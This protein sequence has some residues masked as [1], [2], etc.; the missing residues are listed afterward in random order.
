MYTRINCTRVCEVECISKAIAIDI[1]ILRTYYDFISFIVLKQG[2]DQWN[3]VT[4]CIF[5]GVTL[6]AVVSLIIV[7]Q[8]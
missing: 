7:L 8:H 3:L 5:A 1:Y 2:K 6:R 4:I